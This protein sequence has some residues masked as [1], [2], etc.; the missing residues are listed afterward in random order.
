MNPSVWR[1][2]LIL[3]VKV[4]LAGGLLGWL[5]VSGAARFFDCAG[6]CN[7][8][9]AQVCSNTAAGFIFTTSLSP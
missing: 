2:R 9:S 1:G 5:I 8:T 7:Q 6:I 3:L 4:V